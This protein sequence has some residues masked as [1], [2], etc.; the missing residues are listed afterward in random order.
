MSGKRLFIV[1]NIVTRGGTK[2]PSDTSRFFD[3]ELDYDYLD[4][5]TVT[6]RV[7]EGFAV[8]TLPKAVKETSR[9]GTYSMQISY[10]DATITLIRSVQQNSGRYP[11]AHYPELVKFYQAIQKADRAKVVLVKQ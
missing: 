1:P 8:E 4:V 5:D 11:P 9:F 10:A 6:I 3:I 2:L 7:P